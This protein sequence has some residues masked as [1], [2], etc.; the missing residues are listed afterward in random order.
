MF[1]GIVEEVGRVAAVERHDR[2]ARLHIACAEVVRDV[3][4]GDSIAVAG[5]CL[6]VSAFTAEGFVADLM[7]ETLAATA[8]GDLAEGDE[9]NLERAMRADARLGGHLVQGHVDAVGEVVAREEEPGTVWLSVA[10]PEALARY[11][12]P[13]GSVTVDGASLTVVD[14]EPAEDGAVFR[15]GLIPHTLKVTTFGDRRQGDRVNLEFDVIA[16]YAER[17]LAAGTQTPY[18]APQER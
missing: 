14:V 18:S 9:V 15:V 3:A 7:A 12:V 13:K 10:T 4:E 5:C 17:L 2:H 1:T 16:K 6:T 11:L 8:L